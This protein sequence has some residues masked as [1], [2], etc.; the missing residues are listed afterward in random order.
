MDL[1]PVRAGLVMDPKGHPWSSHRHYIGQT[2]D[3]RLTP[4]P[5]YWSLGNT[6]FAREAAYTELV[7]TGLPVAQQDA[8]TDATLHGWAM[9]DADFVADLQKRTPRRIVRSRPGRPVT[10]PRVKG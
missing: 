5:V 8:I 9:G 1:N 6:P 4:S 7:R 3:R 10:T 2:P